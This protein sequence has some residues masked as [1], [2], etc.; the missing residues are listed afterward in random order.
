MSLHLPEPL[1]FPVGD[2]GMSGDAFPASI[3][4]SSL[5]GE[6]DWQVLN[7]VYP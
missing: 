4:P 3:T 1:F 2:G 5:W 6:W 7:T